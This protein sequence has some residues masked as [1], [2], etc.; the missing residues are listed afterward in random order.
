MEAGLQGGADAQGSYSILHADKLERTGSWS[1]VRR[2]LGISSFGA[3]LVEIAPGES[4][5]EHD[6]LDRDQEEL[7][8]FVTGSPLLVIDGV[9]HRVSTGTFARLD[10]EPRRTIRNDGAEPAQVLIVSAPRSSGYE[11]MGWA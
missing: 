8:V 11:P 5:P 9:E 4:I 1:L 7:F 3:N 6:E 10:P 2:S